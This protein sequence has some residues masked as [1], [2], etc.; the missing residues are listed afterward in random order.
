MSDALLTVALVYPNLG[1]YDIVAGDFPDLTLTPDPVRPHPSAV[2]APV[3]EIQKTRTL[4]E[5]G[6]VVTDSFAVDF[7]EV[8]N[9]TAFVLKNESRQ[10][11]EVSINSADPFPFPDGAVL[12]FA[13][14]AAGS[15][16]I[17][18]IDL[19]CTGS[20]SGD[21]YVDCTLLGIPPAD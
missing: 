19:I 11:L 9:C 12:S 1:Q 6:S 4:I 20:Q 3:T 7:G 21:G 8:E 10:D 2:S 13:S 14:P 17:E 5:D 16:P 18:S 15:T